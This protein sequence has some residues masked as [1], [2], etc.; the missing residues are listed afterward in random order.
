[1]LY[2][3]QKWLPICHPRPFLSKHSI[4]SCT[5]K[6]NDNGDITPPCLTPFETAYTCDIQSFHLTR[7][8]DQYTYLL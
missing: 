7:M 3:L 8:F 2:H 1:M 5:Y 4:K 6:L